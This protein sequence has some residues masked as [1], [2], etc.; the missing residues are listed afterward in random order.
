MK[1]H[2]RDV[3]GVLGRIFSSILRKAMEREQQLESE[4]DCGCPGFDFSSDLYY[5]VPHFTK[6]FTY[7][8]IEMPKLK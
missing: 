8:K 7:I 5:I 1:R 6:I 4:S 2:R 3:A